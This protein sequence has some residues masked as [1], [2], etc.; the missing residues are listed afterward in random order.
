MKVV[1]FL[2][3]GGSAAGT[4]AS[5][6]IRGLL[7]NASITIVTDEPHEE[8]SRVLLPQYITHKVER[9]NIFLKKADWYVQKNIVL[10]KGNSAQKIETSKKIVT[11]ANGEE[12]QYGKLLI[13]VGGFPLKLS[14]PGDDLENRARRTRTL[15]AKLEI[16][17]REHEPVVWIHHQNRAG[18]VLQKIITFRSKLSQ[19]FI[20][21]LEGRLI[22]GETCEEGSY[23]TQE[24]EN[25][26]G[27]ERFVCAEV[28]EI[29]KHK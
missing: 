21:N 11:L 18:T 10:V 15:D 26:C 6:V 25:D 29:P 17:G 1:D 4:T 19:V 13:A 28:H 16:R 12:I 7:P 24:G 9:E 5:E 23:Q 14:V 8:Y 20:L 22:A 2:I 27:G 3:I